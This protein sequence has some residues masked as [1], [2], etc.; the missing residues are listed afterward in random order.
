VKRDAARVDHA[1]QRLALDRWPASARIV[2][3]VSRCARFAARVL[4]A[5]G[6]PAALDTD[7]FT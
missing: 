1:D 5:D 2:A 7:A 6:T 4:A 3:P